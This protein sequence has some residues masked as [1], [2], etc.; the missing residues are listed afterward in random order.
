MI[1]IVV[2]ITTA[3][4]TGI[5]TGEAITKAVTAEAM[6][7]GGIKQFDSRYA[8]CRFYVWA[9]PGRRRLPV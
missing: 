7:R 8:H 2:A 6:V 9:G 3:M 5:T 1:T 4:T